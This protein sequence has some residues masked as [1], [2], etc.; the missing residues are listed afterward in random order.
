[1]ITIGI[2]IICLLV[3]ILWQIINYTT[4]HYTPDYKKEL[5]AIKDE[6]EEIKNEIT[7]IGKDVA[8]LEEDRNK[9]T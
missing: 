4:C 6:L 9:N 1:M 2:I 8:R 7:Y 5:E 3:G